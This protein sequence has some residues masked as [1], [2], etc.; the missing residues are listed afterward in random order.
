MVIILCLLTMNLFVGEII[1]SFNREKDALLHNNRLTPTEKKWAN[2]QLMAYSH[3]P[4][5]YMEQS[6]DISALRN[7]LIALTNHPF[8]DNFIMAVILLNSLILG[9]QYYGMSQDVLDVFE[10][11]N[12][13]FMVIFTVEAIVKL[14]AMKRAYFRDSWN[15]FDF[16][17][18]VITLIVLAISA[19]PD[20]GIDMASQASLLR[21]LR[22][23]RVLRIIKKAKHLQMICETVVEAAPGMASL[24]A[25][26]VLFTFTFSIIGVSLFGMVKI[27][28]SPAGLNKHANF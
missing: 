19:I 28:P 14:I 6:E 1:S 16:T 20:T 22:I 25:L 24:G 12:S 13:S 8:F 5:V 7:A 9:V 11:I 18:V 21:L 26:Y 2:I 4:L 27:D 23:L 17:V 3:K 15:V 10:V